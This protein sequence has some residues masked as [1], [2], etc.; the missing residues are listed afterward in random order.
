MEKYNFYKVKLVNE[1]ES[2]L[3]KVTNLTYF[4]C[5]GRVED[6]LLIVGENGLLLEEPIISNNKV[7]FEVIEDDDELSLSK[8]LE[9]YKNK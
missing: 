8:L 1:N 3:D 2:L 6:R 9:E 7:R 4:L 5:I